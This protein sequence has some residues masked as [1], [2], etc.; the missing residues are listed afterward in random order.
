[1]MKL[2]IRI[3]LVSLLLISFFKAGAAVSR[4]A[5]M[6]FVNDADSLT[7]K[8]N[9]TTLSLLSWS[10]SGK[11]REKPDIDYNRILQFGKWIQF[12]KTKGCYDTRAQVLIRDSI[13]PATSTDAKPCT[14]EEGEWLDSYS[15]QKFNH[16]SEIQIDHMVPLKEAYLAGAYQWT[17]AK[18]CVYA[19]FTGLKEHLISTSNFE[20]Q[21]KSD[22]TPEAYIPP[23]KDY[24]CTYLKNWLTVKMI[25]K[26]SMTPGETNA[27]QKHFKDFNCNDSDFVVERALVDDN[28]ILA[29]KLEALCP[30]PK[31]VKQKM[32]VVK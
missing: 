7:E 1:M 30:V 19:N 32:A 8:S 13:I 29:Q 20:N 10:Q 28:R 5:E 6:L 31:V 18:R 17:R 23:N 11:L 4:P 24:V 27:I 3:I 22:K 14:I 2:Q 9:S 16:D 26:M 15:N 12:K 21:S 25:W